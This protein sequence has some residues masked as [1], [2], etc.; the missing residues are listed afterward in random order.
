MRNQPF[1]ECPRFQR[2]SCND[3]PL[4]YQMGKR[5]PVLRSDPKGS[6][7]IGAVSLCKA[8]RSTRVAIAARY[9]ELPT[10]GLKHAEIVSDKR[11]AA[12]KARWD[13]LPTEE[14]A[15]R[16]ERASLLSRRIPNH[17]DGPQL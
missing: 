17:P 7:P 1:N 15:R 11:S 6:A 10:G 12:G 5:G 14:Q 16:R 13:A 2:C 3:C 4:D 9:P 8:T